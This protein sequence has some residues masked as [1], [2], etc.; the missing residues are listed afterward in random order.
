MRSEEVGAGPRPAL[1]LQ[2]LY[3]RVNGVFNAVQHQHQAEGRR[4]RQP[5]APAVTGK[6]FRR[7]RQEAG[8]GGGMVQQI[9][10]G[11]FVGAEDAGGG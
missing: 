1:Y 9:G 2:P 7:L 10:G 6:A 5:G 4:C 8:D 11:V 3:G